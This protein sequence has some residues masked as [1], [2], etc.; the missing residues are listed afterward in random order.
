MMNHMN[1]CSIDPWRMEVPPFPMGHPGC[2]VGCPR[3]PFGLVAAAPLHRNATHL[4]SAGMSV[5]HT[6]P[7]SVLD[8]GRAEK[9]WKG[10][11]E[12]VGKP[13]KTLRKPW[14]LRAQ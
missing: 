4:R 13:R 1:H 2:G 9:N 7:G 8:M 6:V 14:L 10:P 12:H 11:I 3:C 5:R